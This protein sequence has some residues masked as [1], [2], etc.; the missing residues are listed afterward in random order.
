MI[1]HVAHV[2]KEEARVWR[3]TFRGDLK[4]FTKP[5]IIPEYTAAKLGTR[6]YS[7]PKNN[8]PKSVCG[9]TPRL[10]TRDAEKIKRDFFHYPTGGKN[11]NYMHVICATLLKW[12]EQNCVTVIGDFD[13]DAANPHVE[14]I[15]AWI[16][17]PNK[18]RCCID[19]SPFTVCAPMPKPSCVL[20]TAADFLNTLQPEVC[21]CIVDD[22]QGFLQAHINR[23]SQRFCHLQF[24]NLLLIHRA[25]AFGI[26]VSPPKFQN[27]NRIAVSALN[28]RGIPCLLYLDDR[29][30]IDDLLRPLEEGETGI[31]VYALYCLLVAFG[32][33]C[34]IKK[35]DFIPQ[36][37][38]RFLGFDFD[39]HAQTISV[40][41]EKHEKLKK[42]VAEFKAGIPSPLGKDVD[43]DFMVNIHLL[44]KIRGKIISWC[45]VALNFGFYTREMNEAI[46]K[47]YARFPGPRAEDILMWRS[48]LDNYDELIAELDL[49]CDLEYVSLTRPWISGEHNYLDLPLELYTDASGGGLGS[50]C[51]IG[52]ALDPRKFTLPLWLAPYPIHIKEAYVILIAIQSYGTKYHGKRLIVFCDNE[53]VVAS[54]NGSGSRDIHLARVLK[55]LCKYCHDHNIHLT[56]KWVDTKNQLADE[57]SRQ[58]SHNFARLKTNFAARLITKLGVN[59]DLFATPDDRIGSGIRYYSEYPY[60]GCDGVDG[61]SYKWSD[62]DICYAY[63]PRVLRGPFLK[64]KLYDSDRK[65]YNTEIL[66]HK[67]LYFSRHFYFE[68]SD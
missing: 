52:G 18:P 58:L 31:G 8:K 5:L 23:L 63:C 68:R 4:V 30:V 59:L 49:W 45:L 29:A 67:Q 44:E 35:C 21:F 6:D 66:Q 38:G 36:K 12:I 46:K 28:R 7:L 56:L 65:I 25:L 55:D 50:N 2:P 13:L 47:H 20:D 39:T 37:Q 17:E 61:M 62:G 43:E 9:Y 19:G 34:S 42:L 54:W 26:H 48:E 16:V 15:L 60:L 53:A 24:G 40:P 3:Q 10:V 11:K 14:A 1:S 41:P 64:V 22:H 33:F 27:L 32:G 57:P 51:Y